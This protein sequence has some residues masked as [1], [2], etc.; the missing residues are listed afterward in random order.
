M[1][2]VRVA[3]IGAGS[4]ANHV[5]YPSL[6]SLNDVE[7]VGI[8]DLVPEKLKQTAEKFKIAQ[9]YTDYGQML[10]ETRP[11]AVYAIMPP[12]ILFDVAMDVLERGHHLF[13]EKP[14]GVTVL[15]TDAMARLASRKKLVTGVGFQRRYHP[16]VRACWEETQK[17]GDIQYA[18]ASF[19][20]FFEPAEVLPYYRGAVDFLT[21]D[22]IHIADALRFYTGLS[23]VRSVASEVR[24]LD[25]WYGSSFSALIGFENGAVGVL[26]A[27]YRSGRRVMRFEFHSYGAAAFADIDGEGRVWR[28]GD[29]EPCF[30]TTCEEYAHSDAYHVTQGFQ[31]EARAFIDAVK[32]GEQVH[33]N[34]EDAVKTMLLVDAIRT[35]SIV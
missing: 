9:T 26:H 16:M 23:D 32:A 17:D 28:H 34:F 21:S 20:K 5:H 11:D 3:F 12:H 25:T 35:Q 1:Q 10:K 7:I 8:C 22:V 2:K 31:Q 24:Q 27:N 29:P 4:L 6:V 13:I 18:T 30:R 19:Y 33:N 15:Q 14:P